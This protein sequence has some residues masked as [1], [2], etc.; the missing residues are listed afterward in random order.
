MAR[1]AVL[2]SSKGLNNHIHIDDSTL[3]TTEV[4]RSDDGGW[5]VTLV[6]GECTY[7]VYANPGHELDVEGLSAGCLQTREAVEK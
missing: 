6:Q 4:K 1:N 2:A 5:H 3:V 7:I